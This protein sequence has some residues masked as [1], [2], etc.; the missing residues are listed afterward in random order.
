MGKTIVGVDIG[1]E[2]LRAVEVEG[3]RGA[4]ATV[5]RFHELPLPEGAVR[6]GEV[7]EVNTVAAVLKQLWS[8]GGFKSKKVVLGVGNSKVLVRELTVPQAS[9][10]VRSAQP[11]RS[12]CR[13]C[14]RCRWLTPSSISTPCQKGTQKA[15]RP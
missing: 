3:G 4:R 2:S 15:A 13:T 10:S 1:S 6:N 9:A 11:S 7:V 12:R 8:V 14:C 5:V